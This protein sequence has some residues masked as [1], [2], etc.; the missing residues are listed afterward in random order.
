[1]NIESLSISN[2]GKHFCNTLIQ[3]QYNYLTMILLLIKVLDYYCLQLIQYVLTQ[4]I[5]TNQAPEQKE[6]CQMDS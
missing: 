2:L 4:N 6:I 3:S 1:M 5:L